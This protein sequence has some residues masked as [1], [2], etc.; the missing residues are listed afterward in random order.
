[1][2]RCAT[3]AALAAEGLTPDQIAARL[4]I[5]KRTVHDRLRYAVRGQHQFRVPPEALPALTAHAE[6]RNVPVRTLVRELLVTAARDGLIDAVLDD[7]T[8]ETA[9]A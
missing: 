7:L 6:A 3:A 8:P 5:P 4:G 1:M 2:T 9:H